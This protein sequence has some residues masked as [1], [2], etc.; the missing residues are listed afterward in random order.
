SLIESYDN[1]YV[2]AGKI[3]QDQ[4]PKYGWIFKTDINGEMLWD[5]K[6]GEYGDV[7]AVGGI[8]Q[9]ID[10]GYI[11]SGSTKKLDP[12]Y[13][14]FIMKLNACGVKEWCKILHLPYNMDFGTRILQLHNGNYIALLTY[15]SYVYSERIWLMCFDD[16]GNILWKKVYA[17][18]EPDI[19]DEDG[20]HLLLTVDSSIIITGIGAYPDSG[21]T[22]YKWRPLFIKTDFDG[23]EKWTLPWGYT[24]YFKGHGVMSVED[25]KGNIY[26]AGRHIRN[27]PNYGYSPTLIKTS[28]DGEELFYSDVY[29]S[30]ELGMS[31]T[32]SWFADST[33]VIGT[34]WRFPDEE[35]IEAV[36]KV[37]TTGNIITIKEL[38]ETDNTFQGSIVDFDNKC[39]LMGGFYLDGNWDIYAYKFNQELE[40]DT[41][42]TLPFV[43]DSLCPYPIVSDTIPLD[44]EVVGLEEDQKV[45]ERPKLTI[46][47]NPAKDKI[48]VVLPEHITTHSKAAGFSVTTWR[49]QFNGD[50]Q[51]EI[52]D[53]YGRRWHQ[54][55]IPGGDKEAE[56]PVRSLPAGLY[57]VRAVID[58]KV[59]SGKFVKQ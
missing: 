49:Y 35:V 24:Q 32:I 16:A 7:T 31:T 46:I 13:D 41:I 47:P 37:D 56:I 45:V 58:G 34:G 57:V 22:N 3:N 11:L 59:V 44:C 1:G 6:F 53:M 25:N 36:I 51:L 20:F 54:Q 8:K 17:Q 38:I 18:T 19:I 33:L 14:P 48:K 10:N 50:I 27:Q 28:K 55:V 9:T 30:T 39:V 2:Y 21:T 26:T 43:Y 40:Y 4:I 15:F 42:Y 12:Y 23:N 52:Y 29:D 5:K